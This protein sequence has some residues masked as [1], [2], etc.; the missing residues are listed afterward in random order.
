MLEQPLEEILE[1]SYYWRFAD[2]RVSEFL[3]HNPECGTCQYRGEC[4]GGCRSLALGSD[5][6]D[7]LTPDQDACLYFKGGWKEKKDA[8]LASLNVI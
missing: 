1:D 4:C 7:Y 8:L 2:T 3:D 6:L 5:G